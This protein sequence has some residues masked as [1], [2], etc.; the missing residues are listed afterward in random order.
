MTP[1]ITEKYLENTIYQSLIQ[2]CQYSPGNPK[3][4]HRT[5]CLDI[6]KLSQFLHSTQPEKLT[7]ISN[8]HGTNWEKKLYERLHRQIQEKSIVN[9]LRQGIKTGETHLELYY[10]LPTSRL[11][12][13]TIQNYQKNIFSVTRQLKYKENHNL[14]L[15]LVIFINGLPVITFELKNQLTGQNFQDAINQ[16]KNDRL[17]SELLFQFKRCLVHFA[18]DTNE[19]WMTT[20]LDGKNTKFLPFNKGKKSNSALPFA[21]TA[22]NPPHPNRIKTD[23]LW[24]EILAK[25]TLSNIIENYAQL[26]AEENKDRDK[27]SAKKEKLIFPRYHQLDLVRQLLKHT[28]NQGVGNRYLIQH[29]AD[30]GKSNSIT[31]LSHQLVE[32]KNITQT[33]TIFDS[34]LVVTDRKIL[35]TQ[36]RE[37]IQQFEQ[38]AGVV[39][40]I[41]GGSKQLK[42]ALEKGSKIIITTVQKFPYVV[43]EIQSLADKNFA[44]IIDEAHSSQTGKSAAK[45][46]ESLSKEDSEEEE[47]T[48]DK[49][50]RIIESQKPCPNANYYAFTATPKNK[51]LELFGVKNPADGKFYPFH[52]YSMKQ[53]IKEGFILDVLQ[54]YTTYKTYCRLQK[55]IIDDPEFNI[56]Q[57]KKKLKR[58]VEEHPENIAKK[59]EVMIEHFLSNVIS[60]GKIN[61]KAKAMVVSNSIKSAIYYK[62]AFDKYLSKINSKYK[63]IVAFSGSKEIDGKKEDEYSMNGFSGD[64]IA[65]AFKEDKYRFLIVANKYQTGFDEPLLHTMY[66]DKVLSDVKAIQTLSRLNRSCEGKRDTF[67][68]DF[69]NSADEIQK[70]FEPYYKTTILSEETNSDR[71]HDL[72]DSL[73]KFHIYSPEDV[74]EFMSKFV[75]SES[76]ENW[77]P[78]LDICVENYQNNLE[79][80]EKI[81]FQ[82]KARS[83]VRNYQFLVQVKSFKNSDWESLNTFLKLLF[84]KL[85]KLD[86]YDLSAG[87]INSVDIE[88]YRVELLGSQSIS[89]TRKNTLS[90]IAENI[91]RGNSENKSD[92]ISQIIQ[93]FNNRFGGSIVWQNQDK[94]WKFLLEELPE[95]VRKD[96]EYQNAINY[97]D[98]QNAKLTFENKFSQELRRYIREHLEEYRQF[99]DNK[100][101][102]E[103]LI[104]T[105][106]NL[107]YN[108]NKTA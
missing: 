7:E 80:E 92:K 41:T 33:E 6:P 108:Q 24:K 32:L 3:E 103:W 106:F 1:D 66:V 40:A 97:S 60:K 89:L 27:K 46:S 77:E 70:A 35:D 55:K 69:V 78:V 75:S 47:T 95:K 90:P 49:I 30:S 2:D 64:K 51:T 52:N 63:T 83:F 16:Y 101:F 81:E 53:A 22:G 11:N 20:K 79:E 25:E 57:A 13:D 18:L 44:I 9:I 84:S 102:R 107:D 8:Y 14:A 5:Y 10:K 73:A 19:V 71:L 85:P 99:T 67:V 72:E 74:Q 62:L 21:D 65:K 58:Y 28:K 23:Y 38:T 96:G 29:S 105:L 36:I 86:N 17:P 98:P 76:R 48:E 26:T 82:N 34:V 88:S 56:K 43:E 68:L 87:I 39:E 4:Y 37:N 45:M 91:V 93:E 104:N 54:N 31:W 12:R 42:S 61:G 15:D 59:A 94:T 100:N 50:I